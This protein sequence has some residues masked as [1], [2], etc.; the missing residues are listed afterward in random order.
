MTC[1]LLKAHKNNEIDENFKM[2]NAFVVPDMN[3]NDS[4]KN[5]KVVGRETLSQKPNI[6]TVVCK[7]CDLPSD[8]PEIIPSNAKQAGA[9]KRKDL[10]DSIFS[11]EKKCLLV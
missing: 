1:G 4:T 8:I 10:V 6:T 7:Q 2:S 9:V 11:S 5:V 3:L